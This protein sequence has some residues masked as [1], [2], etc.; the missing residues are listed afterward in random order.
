M[1][2][3]LYGQE[4]KEVNMQGIQI[5]N[6]EFSFGEHPLFE[7]FSLEI[8]KGENVAI[9][10]SNG[11]GK[12]TLSRLITGTYMPQK[13]SISID[14][15]TFSEEHY[16]ELPKIR[17]KISIVLQN[18]EDQF[19]GTTVAE[20]IAFGLENY[21]VPQ[22]LMQ[23]RIEQ[24]ANL[25]GVEHLLLKEPHQLSGGQKQRVAIASSLALET[26]Y[27][28]FD[29]ATSQLDPQGKEEVFHVMSDLIKKK[30]KNIICITHD[31]KEVFA[32]DR[33]IV[34]NQGKIV[35]DR[36]PEALFFDETF[37]FEKYHLVIP[38]I[39]QYSKILYQKKYID[40][41]YIKIEDLV[42]NLCK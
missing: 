30:E 20:D 9:I 34:M 17:K 14:G 37:P 23:E 27:L 25:V 5:K 33:V 38:E 15:I 10:G 21:Q 41:M 36:R 7:H 16:T 35:A 12:T 39:L 28:I 42:E 11:S 32:F 13:G 19:I 24:Y 2:F 31:I 29:E 18:P 22:E 26:D 40:K 3:K 4:R 1:T 6:I 8:K